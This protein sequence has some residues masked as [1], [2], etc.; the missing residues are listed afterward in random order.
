MGQ[1]VETR[2][3][4]WAVAPDQEAAD[5]STAAALHK[6]LCKS[7]ASYKTLEDYRA[8]AVARTEEA[9]LLPLVVFQP[10]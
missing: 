10:L 1:T 7:S 6:Q 3:V 2:S 8:K 9:A 4:S 5:S